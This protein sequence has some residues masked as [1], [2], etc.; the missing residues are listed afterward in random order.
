[1]PSFP[2]DRDPL[3]WLDET[4]ARAGQVRWIG[5]GRLCV[6]DADIARTLLVD[7]AGRVAD[8]SDFF[9]NSPTVLAPRDR[10]IALARDALALVQAHLRTVDC[11]AE[12]ASLDAQSEWPAAG[13]ALL[14]RIMRPVLAAPGRS[15]QFQAAL[16]HVVATRILSRHQAPKGLVRRAWDRF[17][18]FRAFSREPAAGRLEGDLLDALL[19]HA[20]DLEEEALVQLY[21]GFVFATVGSVG[22]ALGW[23]LLLAAERDRIGYP[24]P[25]HLVHE[26]LR[27]FPV[28]WLF[29]RSTTGHDEIGGET[30]TPADVLTISP[31]AIHRHPAYWEEPLAYR[32]ERWQG[33]TG[34][35]PWFPF[36]AGAH[37]C[38]AAG[39]TL[40]FVG[41]LLAAVADRQPSVER[42][43]GGP[44]LGAALAPPRF[45]LRLAR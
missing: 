36:G 6:Y 35:I 24:R 12:A 41:S 26:A 3:A 1:M 14:L 39:L 37:S 11:A 28:A 44:S 2:F 17:R 45:L 42:L 22:F 32:P 23:S 43:G 8:H 4:A 21:A 9:G 10:Q 18:F 13:S 7:E 30:V 16:D 25:S 27:L 19:R 31:Y 5:P 20:G 38:V 15:P 29:E 33:R 34:R 40:E